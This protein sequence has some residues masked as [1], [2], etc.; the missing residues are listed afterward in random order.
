MATRDN[1]KIAFLYTTALDRG[2][3]QRAFEIIK[4]AH[5]NPELMGILD[6]INNHIYQEVKESKRLAAPVEGL[7][8]SK[9]L[10]SILPISDDND[11][12]T[13]YQQEQ[14]FE[15]VMAGLMNDVTNRTDWQS[16]KDMGDRNPANKPFKA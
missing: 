1:E 12:K 5:S 10:S 8:L 4:E 13:K 7:D 2:D 3:Y 15:R 16:A 11:P 9:P 14:N 6:G